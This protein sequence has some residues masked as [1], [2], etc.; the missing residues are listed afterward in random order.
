[1]QLNS[2]K[3]T[4]Y[5][6]ILL[7]PI[8]FLFLFFYL[9]LINMLLTVVLEENLLYGDTMTVILT[10]ITNPLNV[11]IL[12][13][14][15]YQAFLSTLFAVIIGIPGA[16]ILA[17]YDFRGKNLLNALMTVPFVLP[18]IVVVLGFILVYGE[19]GLLNQLVNNLFGINP[20]S[21]EGTFHGVILAHVFY[22]TPVIIRLVSASWEINDPDIDDVSRT[23]GSSG[24]HKFRHITLPSILPGLVAASLLVFIYCFT[25]FAVVFSVGG[26]HYKT[27]EVRIYESV[28]GFRFDIVEGAVLAIVQ[29]IT[30]TVVLIIYISFTRK[31]RKVE[32]S[33]SRMATKKP[34]LESKSAGELIKG[35]FILIYFLILTILF[36][37]PLSVI[38]LRSIMLDNGIL[39]IEGFTTVLSAKFNQYLGTSPLNQLFNTLVFSSVVAIVS[40][41]LG[42][43]ASYLTRKAKH[44]SMVKNTLFIAFI[45]PMATSGIIMAFSMITLFQESIIMTS[46]AWIAIIIAHVLV[47]FPF[48]NR[49]IEAS[50]DKINPDIVDVARTLGGSRWQIFQQIELPLLKPGIIVSLSFA[51]AISVGEF[52]ATNFIARH[53]FTTIAVGVYQFLSTRQF[54]YSAAMASVLI[55]ICIACFMLIEKYGRLDLGI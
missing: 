47:S 41:T 30:I 49:T 53:G 43:L 17:N 15:F 54:I 8:F 32:S 22:N 37:F 27:L 36:F 18:A 39:T 46:Q 20:F 38:L 29:L 33:R 31:L 19:A 6:M 42:L 5:S 50:L 25:S 24:W 51:F 35:S 13:F 40:V 14:T 48:I 3:N 12:L 2:G 45:L 23:L 9:P 34:L 26:V 7:A 21:F 28:K 16:Y 52:G 55:F 1:M 10:I 44:Y 4:A 11:R